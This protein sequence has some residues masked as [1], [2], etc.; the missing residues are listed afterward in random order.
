[1]VYIGVGP[2][3]VTGPWNEASPPNP[4]WEFQASGSGFTTTGSYAITIQ[5]AGARINS[6]LQATGPVNKFQALWKSGPMYAFLKAH[7]V[8]FNAGGEMMANPLSPGAKFTGTYQEAT[9]ITR[10]L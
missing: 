1:M 2:G 7:G 8:M 3:V 10:F 9:D 6:V 5:G 4:A